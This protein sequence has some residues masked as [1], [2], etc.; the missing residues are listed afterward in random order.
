MEQYSG[1]LA[2]TIEK[3]ISAGRGVRIVSPYG[4]RENNMGISECDGLS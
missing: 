4:E 2:E 1:P 3:Q